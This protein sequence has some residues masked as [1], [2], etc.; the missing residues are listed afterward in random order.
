M[1][2]H[3]DEIQGSHRWEHLRWAFT[4]ETSIVT[5]TTLV[6]VY[7]VVDVISQ[8]RPIVL[9]AKGVADASLSQISGIRWLMR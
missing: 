7:R 8:V 9:F 3:G 1:H 4:L 6:C 2:V 5:C